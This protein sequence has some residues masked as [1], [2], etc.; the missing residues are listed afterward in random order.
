[1]SGR[2]RRQNITAQGNR[3]KRG[4]HFSPILAVPRTRSRTG[5]RERTVRP[6]I[7]IGRQ[8]RA[9]RDLLGRKRTQALAFLVG[10][11]NYQLDRSRVEANR[12][13]VVVPEIDIDG[14][15]AGVVERILAE[16]LFAVS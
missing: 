9:I 14:D 16:N 6:N 15:D 5:E 7:G 1:M 4:G 12:D 11:R 3:V 8:E 10:L 13:A 2:T